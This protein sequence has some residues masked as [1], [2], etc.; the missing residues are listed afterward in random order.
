[1]LQGPDVSSSVVY[2]RNAGAI[3]GR[4]GD[5]RFSACDEAV[6]ASFIRRRERYFH[7]GGDV[8]EVIDE[9]DLVEIETEKA[10][11]QIPAPA[12]GYLQSIT[13]QSDEGNNKN[14]HT[15]RAT[16]QSLYALPHA[17]H[18]YLVARALPGRRGVCRAGGADVA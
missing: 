16:R 9:E 14:Y 11:V 15:F 5:G 2:D 6:H 7:C 1:M 13:K 8:E 4:R 10:S 18:W 17:S 3:Y 12:S